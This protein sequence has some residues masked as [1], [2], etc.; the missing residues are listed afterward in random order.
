MAAEGTD[1]AS[2]AEALGRTSAQL[3]EARAEARLADELR[4]RLLADV[5]RLE[6][7][8]QDAEAECHELAE[9]VKHRDRLLS[10][11]FGS[12]SWR[13]TQALRRSLKR[14]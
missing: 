14:E 13:W 5:R 11:V 12:R 1:P 6:R 2:L 4:Q 9:K 8:L 3:D 7:R 10:Q